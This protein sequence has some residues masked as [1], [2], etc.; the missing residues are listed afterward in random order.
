[1]DQQRSV[2]T[3]PGGADVVQYLEAAWG[4]SGEIKQVGEDTNRVT[5][6]YPRSGRVPNGLLVSEA[7]GNCNRGGGAL[8][9]AVERGFSEMDIQ[10]ARRVPNGCLAW[11][12]GGTALKEADVAEL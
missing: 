8:D 7:P 3:L 1:V 12:E 4:A 6:L 11:N 5:R 9:K 10:I 2:A